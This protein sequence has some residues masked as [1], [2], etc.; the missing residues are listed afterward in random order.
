LKINS[1]DSGLV[2]P[3]LEGMSK[4][5]NLSFVWALQGAALIFL[6]LFVLIGAL[7]FTNWQNYVVVGVGSLLSGGSLLWMAYSRA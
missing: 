2:D 4:Y 3:I 6:G 7:V 1:L 5:Q